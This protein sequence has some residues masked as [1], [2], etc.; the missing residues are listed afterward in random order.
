MRMGLKKKK[1]KTGAKTVFQTEGGIQ[2]CSTGQFEKIG[3]F[4]STKACKPI[5]VV[6]QNKC[7]NLKM[8][9]SFTLVKV[10]YRV[11]VL[12]CLIVNIFQVSQVIF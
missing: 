4:L 12:N 11:K 6:T 8:S 9:I 10:T 2:S 7:M 1:K 3:V 5:L